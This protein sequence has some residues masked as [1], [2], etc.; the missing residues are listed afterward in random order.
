MEKVNNEF[1]DKLT[2]VFKTKSGIKFF[3]FLDP[4]GIPAIR[5]VAAE[6]AKRFLDMNITERSMKDLI[7]VC[8][9]EAGAGDIVRAFSVIQEIE[10]RLNFICEES[11]ILDLA[12]IYFMLQDEDPEVP[13]EA[14][15]REKH[16]I[17]EEDPQTRAFFL[18]IGIALVKKFSEKREEDLIG[19]LE[20]NQKMSDRIR[21]Y[22]LEES[23]ITS[24][25]LSTS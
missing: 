5:G 24:T 7:R 4:L 19:Y 3:G 1:N 11:S 12:C 13:S 6:K 14:K 21:R 2:E 9:A 20:E 25:P 23:S 15:N 8:K 10:Y 18:R 22:I 17:F 16:K